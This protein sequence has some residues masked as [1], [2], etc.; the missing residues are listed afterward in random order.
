[1]TFARRL[2]TVKFSLAN[3]QF[4]GGGNELV[5][6][7]LRV[8]CHILN[9]GGP[10]A[11]QLQMAIWGMSLSQMNQLVTVGPNYLQMYKNKVQVFAGDEDSGTSLI[12]AGDIVTATVDAK[13]MPNVCLRI[14][15]LPGA[16]LTVA[17][18]T[19]LSIQG[20]GDVDSMLKQLAQT[21]GFDGYESAGINAKLNN[22][23]YA[24]SLWQQIQQ[25]ARDGGIDVA[26]DRGTLCAVAPGS[27]RDGVIPVVA[28]PDLLPDIIM[29]GYPEFDQ[30]AIEV[31]ALFSPAVQYYGSIEVRSSLQPANGTWKVNRLEY[32]L[33]AN[34]PS[35]H[36]DMAIAGV[37]GF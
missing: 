22:P 10:M 4:E 30:V 34:L 6:S 29:I 32:F 27:T 11:G 13:Q 24:G 14:T 7:G 35:G 21:A 23:Y 17:P 36:W 28:P 25:I 20:S 8:S 18:A 31:S 33:D 9:T 5:I 19:P 2:I 3:G 1:M 15:S 16:W 26:V 12:W 37:G